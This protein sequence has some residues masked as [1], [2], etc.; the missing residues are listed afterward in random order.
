MREHVTR[1]TTIPGGECE[2]GGGLG[3]MPSGFVVCMC[4]GEP[5]ENCPALEKPDYDYYDEL[6][7][8]PAPEA[9]QGG[10]E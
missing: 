9:G 5:P 6:E 10:A 3:V 2:C 4:C 8:R 7:G 1:V